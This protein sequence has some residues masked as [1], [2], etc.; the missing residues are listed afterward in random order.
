MTKC[1]KDQVKKI[2]RILLAKKK[3]KHIPKE[4]TWWTCFYYD[5]FTPDELHC[6]HKFLGTLDA[7]ALEEVIKVLEQYFDS[8]PF[9]TFNIVF[10]EECFFGK[11][12]DVRV[13]TPKEDVSSL[14]LLDLKSKLDSFREDEFK[15]YKPHDTTDRASVDMP[16]KGYALTYDDAMVRVFKE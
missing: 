6:T 1:L 7:K 16:F 10:S 5:G 2:T 8:K 15:P 3:E 14:M 13:L 9:K 4:P 11:D 12:K